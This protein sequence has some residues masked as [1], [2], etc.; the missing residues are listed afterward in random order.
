MLNGL[1][2]AGVILRSAIVLVGQRWDS[3]TGRTRQRHDFQREVT[4]AAP[5]T[6][7]P[8]VRATMQVHFA[9]VM[10]DRKTGEP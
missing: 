7:N 8:M 5:R 6:L 2:P 9:D 4:T 3:A 1:R 10:H